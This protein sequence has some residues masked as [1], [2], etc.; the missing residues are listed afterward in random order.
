MYVL[1]EAIRLSNY[2]ITEVVLGGDR[3]AYSLGKKWALKNR[4]PYKSFS[5]ESLEQK[6]NKNVL[7]AHYAD[8]LI[9]VWD[10]IS[11]GVKRMIDIMRSLG[12]LVYVYVYYPI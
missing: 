1:E 10:D 7:M 2:E 4:I 12:K 8:A 9:A 5:A 11:S 3:G 6:Q